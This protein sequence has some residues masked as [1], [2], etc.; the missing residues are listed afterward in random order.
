MLIERREEKNGLTLVLR[1]R[2]DAGHCRN[3][4]DELE[5][6]L[7]RGAFRV[8]LDM[9]GIVFLSSAGIRSLLRYKKTL[10]SLGGD[11]SVRRPSEFVREIL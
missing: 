9:D 7:R 10:A 3:L 2:L 8:A 1:G 11:L 6:A 4:E 5:S